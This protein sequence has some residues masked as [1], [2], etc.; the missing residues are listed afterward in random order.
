MAA[1]FLTAGG[2]V[3]MLS[4][5]EIVFWAVRHGFADSM[6]FFNATVAFICF[7]FMFVFALLGLKGWAT[8]RHVDSTPHLDH[9]V[10]PRWQLAQTTAQMDKST[11]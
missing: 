2:V 5:N 10:R 9:E 4:S 8:R 3:F 1:F 11:P 7:V 6:T